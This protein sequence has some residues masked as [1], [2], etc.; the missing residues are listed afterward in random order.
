MMGE[1]IQ[2]VVGGV[3]V[4]IED[5]MQSMI[6][7]IERNNQETATVAQITEISGVLEELVERII[8][9]T[10]V[11]RAN[12]RPAFSHICIGATTSETQ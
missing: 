6:W 11:V 3:D 10:A 9:G 12:T 2:Q 4:R 1:M 7:E 5:C 8:E